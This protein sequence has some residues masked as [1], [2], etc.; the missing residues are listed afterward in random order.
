MTLAVIVA[1]EKSFY[2]LVDTNTINEKNG[3]YTTRTQKSFYSKKH[4][5]GLCM[6]GWGELPTKPGADDHE[7]IPTDHIFRE[8]FAYAETLDVLPIDHFQAILLEF[9][10]SKFPPLVVEILQA[11]VTYLYGGFRPTEDGSNQTVIAAHYEE[12]EG[13]EPPRAVRDVVSSYTE[14]PEEEG[15]PYYFANVNAFDMAVAHVME[16]PGG[17]ASKKEFL[18]RPNKA[19][20]KAIEGWVLP[21]ASEKM[22]T[23]APYFIGKYF[24]W[25]T[26]RP[27]GEK[28][29]RFGYAYETVVGEDGS[30]KYELTPHERPV[31]PVAATL[32]DSKRL[33]FTGEIPTF[34]MRDGK[35]FSRVRRR[36]DARVFWRHLTDTGEEHK[37]DTGFNLP[38]AKSAV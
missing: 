31:F 8:F 6:A 21:V 23:E 29:S 25:T 20:Q 37:V 5:V 36:A 15:S 35:P 38:E 28:V 13:D 22:Q 33:Q 4:R 27:P 10:A 30:E 3:T 32:Y 14:G 11:H 12:P 17:P 7:R 26:I 9:V 18:T 16:Y 34:C 1:R 19:N 24:V 2:I